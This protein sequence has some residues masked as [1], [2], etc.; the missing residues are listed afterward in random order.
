MEFYAFIHF[1]MN[2]FTNMEWGMG[3]EKPEQ[4]NPTNL[5]CR[6]WARVCKDAG[7]KG[8]ILTA[9]HH[10]GFCLWPSQYTDHSVKNSP[11]KDGKGDLVK[12][13]REA[14]DEFGLKLGIYYSPWDRHHKDYGKPAYL[15]YM[16]NQLTELLTEYGEIFE[17]WF[18]GANGGS[19]YYGGANEERKVDKQTYYDWLDTW[20]LVH[21]LQ[22][23]TLIFSD[24]GPDIRWVGNEEG[25]AFKTM[26]SNLMRDSVYPG[27]VEYAEKFASGQE[28]GT[29]FVPGET[30]VSI[31]PGW[32]YHPYEDH[33]VRSL[34]ELTEMYYN[35]IGRN[36]TWLLNFPVDKRGLIHENDI[37]QLQKL[38]DQIRSDFATNLVPSK[39]VA[40]ASST[41]GTDYSIRNV[42]D[43]RKETYWAAEDHVLKA[44][45]IFEFEQYLIFNR[46]VLQE[47]IKL[48]QR[49]KSFDIEVHTKSGWKKIAEETTIGYKRI[50]RFPTVEGRSLRINIKESKACPTLSNIAIYLAKPVMEPPSAIRNKDGL[51]NLMAPGEQVDIFYTIDGSVPTVESNKFVSPFLAH[52]P[53]TIQAIAHK[54]G[55]QS[56]TAIHQFDI[57]ASKWK[58]LD[59]HGAASKVIDGDPDTWWENNEGTQL[60][61]DLG[62]EIML[63]GFTYLP[64][65]DRWISG[66][67]EDYR[68]ETSSN[69]K[70]WLMATQGEFSNIRNSPVLQEVAF[71]PI[72]ARYFRF[73]ALSTIDGKPPIWAEVA[74]QTK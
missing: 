34:Y 24:A 73:T 58:I 25:F 54:A 52:E 68:I 50:L 36:T 56:S 71:S 32:Y 19:G 39:T 4:F 60:V 30:N 28:Y 74:V 13:L 7:L 2:T 1:N 45:L 49:V 44:S 10:D 27:M 43:D 57:S 31:R 38:T 62:E 9:K 23:G 64:M 63:K 6:Q 26:W 35:S 70:T 3:S 42:F 22:P 17:T 55:D 20:D 37:A 40:T 59:N 72:K 16:R 21:K 8:I 11:W 53:M 12:D 15:T 48:G 69:A 61:I 51:V 46:L 67:I 5:D 18:D 66:V 41:R 33:K 65:Q 29:H 14:C 47:Y